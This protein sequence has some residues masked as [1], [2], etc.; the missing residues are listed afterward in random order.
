MTGDFGSL[1]GRGGSAEV[2]RGGLD[3]GTAVTVKRI[4]G[5]KLVGE[6]EDFLREIS[7]VANVHHRSLVRLLGYGALRGGGRYLVYPFFENGSLD[8][9]LVAVPRRGEAAPPAVADEEP[10]RRRRRQGA[11]VPPP[12]VPA[13]GY[14][15]RRQAGE[16]PPRR[17]PP[18]A[19]VRLRRL[20]VR[21][22]GPDHRRHLR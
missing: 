3:D 19:R 22:P 1:V 11:R 5:D 7:V 18:G 16:H 15:P 21:S 2:F 10:H 17:R 9:S 12:R 14:A 6:E 13:A 20:H 8:W 4:T